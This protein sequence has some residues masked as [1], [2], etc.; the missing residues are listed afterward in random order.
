MIN[1]Q[2]IRNTILPVEG[3][4]SLMINS[5]GDVGEFLHCGHH[6]QSSHHVWYEKMPSPIAFTVSSSW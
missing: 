5:D 6:V 3:R 1:Y 2:S 4:A